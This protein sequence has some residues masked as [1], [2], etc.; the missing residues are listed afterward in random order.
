MEKFIVKVR[1]YNN[2]SIVKCGTGVAVKCGQAVLTATHVL[3]G[4]R[5]TVV[6]STEGETER[7]IEA[8]IL[9]KNDAA[10]VLTV[11]EPLPCGGAGIFSDQELLEPEIPWAVDGYITDEQIAHEITGIGITQSKLHGADWN[12]ELCQILS[13]RA[14]NYRGLSGAP[15]LSCGR[16]VG[17]LQIQFPLENGGLGLRMSSVTLFRELLEDEDLKPNAYELEILRRSQQMSAQHIEQNKKTGKYIPDIFVEE[18]DYK[19]KLRYFAE[20]CRFLKKALEE[21]KRLDFSVQNRQLE[22]LHQPI[23]DASGLAETVPVEK[24]EQIQILAN[25]FL[26]HTRATLE[27]LYKDTREKGMTIEEYFT[28]RKNSNNSLQFD[29]QDIAER[30]YMT[31]KNYVL[32]TKHAGQGKTNL[33]CDFTENFL[34]KKNYCVWYYNAYEMLE[35]PMTYL[36]REWKINEQY[37]LVYAKKILERL[38]RRTGKPVILVIDGLNENVAFNDFGGC[39]RDFLKECA[40]LPYLKIIMTTREELL[41]ERFGCLLEMGASDKFCHLP[42]YKSVDEFKNR[43]FWGYLQFFDV[44]IQVD[45]LTQ[46]TYDM[47]TEDL[48]LLRFFCEVETHKRQIYMYNI[49]KYEVFQ[50][51]LQKKAEEYQQPNDVDTKELFYDLLNHI[52]QTMLQ[53]KT[54]F[55]IPLCGFTNYE[56]RLMN[57]M[58]ENDM[59][60]KSDIQLQRGLF[61][62]DGTVISFTFD[63]FRDFCLVNYILEQSI[64]KTEFLEFWHDLHEDHA[65]ICE[66]I[67]RYAFFLASTKY[68]DPLLP[69]IQECPEYEQL[70][71][72]NIWNIEDQY[73][74]QEDITKWKAQILYGNPYAPAVVRHLLNRC[75]DA[76]FMTANIHTLF[77]AMDE[78]LPDLGRYGKFIRWMFAPSRN[79]RHG[80]DLPG[81]GRVFPYNNMLE[82]LSKL[83]YNFSNVHKEYFHLTIYLYELDP[84]ETQKIWINIFSINPE[85]AVSLLR[86]INR[87][88]RSLIRGNV[89]D[90]LSA[91]LKEYQNGAYGTVLAQLYEENDFGQNFS[92]TANQLEAMFNKE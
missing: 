37:T 52:C 75:D 62:R 19:E 57:R 66:G 47:L 20:P 5:H 36:E 48:L 58:L 44:D 21:C 14:Q 74:T 53:S 2:E 9:Q 24:I 46:T 35:S 34:L 39:M 65:T 92:E 6:V 29:V 82:K 43:I 77:E 10:A 84:R 49:Y 68:R 64:G 42:I 4:T 26:E 69:W 1:A 90:I 28:S 59:I 55:Q 91:L 79:D 61:T 73:L 18:G 72:E 41:K 88:K 11:Q 85:T 45:T 67:E 50:R 33:L 78:I 32:L 25:D 51:Y 12:C 54:Y 63:E 27:M 17:V 31:G 8:E 3:C 23:I 40:A 87:H 38:W 22:D 89:K 80:M 70:Y 16:I 83:L 30:I 13:G 81:R 86:N 76:Y 15:V 60:F 56:Q 7:E 71:W